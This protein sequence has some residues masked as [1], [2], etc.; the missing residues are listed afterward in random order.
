MAKRYS[1]RLRESLV[2]RMTGPGGISA[3]QLAREVG[4]CQQTL[5]RWREAA[6][7]VDPMAN[8]KRRPQDWSLEEILATVLEASQ[9]PEPELGAFLRHKGLHRSHLEDWRTRLAG[10]LQAPRGEGKPSPEAKRVK[11]LEKELGRKEKALA[12][13]AALLVLQKKVR[14]LWGE[15]DDGTPPKTGDGSSS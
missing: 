1:R 14:A 6:D 13:A 11:A 3:T 7:S 2:A 8:K 5:S 4:I 9:L 12:E 15:E 10:A